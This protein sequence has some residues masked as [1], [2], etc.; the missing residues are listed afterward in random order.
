MQALL[1]NCLRDYN[2]DLMQQEDELSKK[3]QATTVT[4][5]WECIDEQSQGLE[6]N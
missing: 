5:S 1:Q 2:D 4:S 6:I 3:Q